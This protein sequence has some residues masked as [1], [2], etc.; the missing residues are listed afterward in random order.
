MFEDIL[1]QKIDKIP[2]AGDIV[3]VRMFNANTKPNWWTNDMLNYCGKQYTVKKVDIMNLLDLFYYIQLGE[4]TFGW[5]WLSI[6]FEE[7][8][9]GEK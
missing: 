6:D 9:E 4:D 8:I 2:K 1:Q 3:T 5:T 7:Y